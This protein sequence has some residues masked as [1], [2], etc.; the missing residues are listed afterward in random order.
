MAKQ[1]R[2]SNA[3][4]Y[5]WL[6]LRSPSRQPDNLVGRSRTNS[7]LAHIWNSRRTR[8]LAVRGRFG[9]GSVA[10]RGASLRGAGAS[11]APRCRSP[12]EAG[13][14]CRRRGRSA[15]GCTALRYGVTTSVPTEC[16]HAMAL[17]PRITIVHFVQAFLFLF[18]SPRLR[19]ATR[20][21]T[22][23][24]AVRK[25]IALRIDSPGAHRRSKFERANGSPLRPARAPT[26]S[27][28]LTHLRTQQEHARVLVTAARTV[29]NR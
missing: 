28:A 26:C 18:L 24:V 4:R 2:S 13:A 29:E 1:K 25:R 7:E 27:S 22:G 20:T 5:V 19:V 6:S 12:Q 16:H 21:T 9:G 17:R 14:I 8:F 10:L 11:L 23:E 15:T 3:V